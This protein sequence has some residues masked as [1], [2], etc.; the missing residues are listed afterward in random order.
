M[1]NFWGV[2]DLLPFPAITLLTVFHDPN[3]V[4]QTDAAQY[5]NIK[6]LYVMAIRNET[7][8]MPNRS[9]ES[10]PARDGNIAIQE[11][12][13]LAV[14]ANKKQALELFLL[15]HPDHALAARAAMVLEQK[16]GVDHK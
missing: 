5:A 4:L 14:T 7:A 9:G 2:S 11:E 1:V 15:R 10:A 8:K 6:P 13:D 16:F 12:Y 3:I